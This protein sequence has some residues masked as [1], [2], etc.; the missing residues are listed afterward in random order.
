MIRRVG[1]LVLLTAA[2]WG[3]ALGQVA[4]E[5]T[6]PSRAQVLK[7][8]SAMGVQENIDTSLQK[9]QNKLKQAA[10]DSFQL[11]RILMRMRRL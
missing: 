1:G 5:S 4:L 2:M 10:H 8:M 11:R 7:L 6:P 9:M 3:A